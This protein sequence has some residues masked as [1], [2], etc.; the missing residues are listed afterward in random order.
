MTEQR[1]PAAMPEKPTLDGLEAVWVARWEAEGTYRFDRSRSRD[2][3][4]SIDTP[5]PTV[6]GSLHVGH[7]FS[8]THTDTIARYQR[9]RGREVFYPMGWDDN[10]L[11]TERRV[12]NHFGV[13]C[14]PSMPYDPGF[15]PPEKPDAKRQVPI[16]RRNFIELCERLTAE[17]EKA[18]EELWRRLGLSV[19]WSMTYA[20]IDADARAASQRAF[21]RNLARGE[22]Y[23]AEAPTLWDV[24]FRT[25]V[26]Q[27]ELEDREWP[28]AFHRIG[29]E[30]PD[31]DGADGMVWIETTRPELIPA[32]VALVAHP[33]DERYRPLFG[34]TVRTPVFG[35]EV[36]V[37]AHHLAEPDKGSG[38]AMICTF[39]DV[40]DVTWW[41]ELDLPTR[42]VIG[43]DGR[44]LPEPPQGVPAEPYAEL[45]GKT[46]H[47]ARERIVEMLRESGHLDGEPRK[48]QRPVKFYEKGDRPL[49]IVTTRQWYIRNGGR[50]AKL[51]AELLERGRELE[52]H[53]PHMRVRYDNW[54]EGLAGDWLISRQ[55]FFGVPIP[56]WYPLD[57][58]G[59]PIYEAPVVPPESAL[60]VDPSSDVPPGFSEDQR[61]KPLGFTADPDVMDTW[62]TSSLS[63]QIA[64]G[65][66]RDDDLFRRVFPMDLRPQAHEIIRTWLF[67]T[68]VRSH[69]EH[70]GLPWRHAAISGWI[71]DPDRK[72]MSKSK[73]NVVTPMGLLEEYGSDAVRYWAANGRPGTDTAFDTGQIKIGR[74][75]AIKILNASKFVLGFRSEGGGEVTEP[76]DLS[77][78]AALGA[79]VAE[80]AEAFESYDYTRA[81]ERTER[82]FWSFCDDYVELV[83]ARAYDG[84]A[85]AVAALR[86]ALGVLLR[87]F[88]PFLPFVTEEVWSWWREGSVHRAAWP[89]PDELP[90]ARYGDPAVLDAVAEVLR[91]V[92]RA[93]SEARL[94][95]RAEVAR[96]TVSGDQTDLVRAA[97]DDLCAAG[98]VEEFVLEPGDGPLDAVAEL[99]RVP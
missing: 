80:A 75:L 53:P 64:A 68:I 72:K 60:P 61:G 67:S 66:E 30:R 3:V 17:D 99:G 54:V 4:Y 40:T 31:G 9:M 10:G 81:L 79:V 95:M 25:A 71:L 33:D 91:R 36:P 43:W 6:S 8:Y 38:I 32:C 84:D 56:V 94:S 73:G 62:A 12:Q 24:T 15:T 44:L 47:S 63:P 22:A 13:R 14:D 35:V 55:R 87:L 97:Q 69:L 48:I 88:A 83:K 76:V 11:P 42:P 1:L 2:E 98:N 85:S 65:W 57:A 78:L 34:T 21:L 52:W 92:R 49:E 77:M 86:R 46:V 27:A 45:A 51:R 7:V 19:D 58:D 96:L 23:V 74:R 70:G 39:G 59:E 82:F 18:F 41:R 29:F 93:K 90:E 26:A 50:D 5:P 89:S 16:S 28:G 37:V 20:T